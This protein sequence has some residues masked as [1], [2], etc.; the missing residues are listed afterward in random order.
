MRQI[1]YYYR[2]HLKRP[3]TTICL[4]RDEDGNVARGVSICSPRDNPNKEEGRFLAIG[5]AHKAIKK[6]RNFSPI[7]REEA[8]GVLGYEQ[9]NTFHGNERYKVRFNPEL[10]NLEQK[11]LNG[12]PND[13]K[14]A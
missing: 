2:D 13:H 5:R 7:S 11:L 1:I 12:K 10:S 6:R 14:E 3:L 4:L 9:M 8:L